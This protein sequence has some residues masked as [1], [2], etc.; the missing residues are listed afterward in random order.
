MELRLESRWVH[1]QSRRWRLRRK[2]G[3][4]GEEGSPVR[5]WSLVKTS[6]GWC[7]CLCLWRRE[8]RLVGLL[9][10]WLE[11]GG[12]RQGTLTSFVFFFFFVSLK[13]EACEP[14]RHIKRERKREIDGV[15]VYV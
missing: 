10:I 1:R 15:L 6:F 11:Q 5:R 7:L 4:E 2:W 3:I 12:G 14:R 13:S 9:L 8:L